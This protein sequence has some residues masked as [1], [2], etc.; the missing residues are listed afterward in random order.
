MKHLIALLFTLL[1]ASPSFAQSDDLNKFVYDDKDNPANWCRNGGFASMSTSYQLGQ[2]KEKTRFIHDN[3]SDN[4]NTDGCPSEDIRQCPVKEYIAAKTS[5]VISKK[6]RDFYCVYDPSNN[7]SAWVNDQRIDIAPAK[8]IQTTDWI[9]NWSSG[10]NS[11]TIKQ[12][13][14][15]LHVLGGALWF[16]ATLDNGSQVVHTGDLEFAEQPDKDKLVYRA[17]EKYECGAELIH[18]GSYLVVRDNASCGGVNV[19]F[20][21]IYQRK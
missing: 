10:P 11:I 6:Y 17:K 5:V 18:L 20:N 8:A 21:G 19:R 3:D 2:I 12:E 14:T 4:K 16:G 7:S 1:I 9:G 13:K 15:G